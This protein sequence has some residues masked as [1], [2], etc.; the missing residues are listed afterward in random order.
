M[1]G[2]DAFTGTYLQVESM[3]EEL[4][5]VAM[6]ELAKLFGS[7]WKR[8]RPKSGDVFISDLR[9]SMARKR[10]GPMDWGLTLG[11]KPT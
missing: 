4:G 10:A 9:N 5:I 2:A 8:P 1:N 7:S 3:T 11:L 6:G